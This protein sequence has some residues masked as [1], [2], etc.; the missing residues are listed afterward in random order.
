MSVGQTIMN[1]TRKVIMHVLQWIAIEADNKEDALL[2]AKRQLE[3]LMG[4]EGSGAT[5]Y[6][7][8]VVGGG[9]WNVAED[10]DWKTGYDEKTNMII[11]LEEDGIDVFKAKLCKP[12]KVIKLSLSC[13]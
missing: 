11:S 12:I 9:R 10:E 4:E 1:T 7:W 5:W 13:T 3:S 2:T 6:D 8:F